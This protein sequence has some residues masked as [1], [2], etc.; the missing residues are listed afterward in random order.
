[1]RLQFIAAVD[2]QL[3]QPAEHA[4]CHTRVFLSPVPLYLLDRYHL[5][6]DGGGTESHQQH[7]GSLLQLWLLY[8]L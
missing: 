1:M 6:D 4:R 2:T 5:Q 8:V 3:F 7:D